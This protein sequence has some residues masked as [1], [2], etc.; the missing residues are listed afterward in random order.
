MVMLGTFKRSC[1]GHGGALQ[2]FVSG[3]RK[4][5][6]EGTASRELASDHC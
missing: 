3:V 2:I 1:W 4:E 6:E 5:M